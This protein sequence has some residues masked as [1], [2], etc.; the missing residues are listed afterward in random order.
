MSLH[1]TLRYLQRHVFP[2]RGDKTT[3]DD[4][5]TEE[6]VSADSELAKAIRSARYVCDERGTKQVF[7]Q[8]GD[9]VIVV[10]DDLVKTVLRP[11]T[12]I[13]DGRHRPMKT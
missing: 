13:I 6:E 9:V 4:F 5:T 7:W 11:G 12:V 1:A 10:L 2:E 8:S 3:L